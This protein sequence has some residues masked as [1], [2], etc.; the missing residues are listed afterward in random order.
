[1]H[2]NITPAHRY[3]RINQIMDQVIRMYACAVV[4][5][6]GN[7]KLKYRDMKMELR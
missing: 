3:V 2:H 6:L 4:H 7:F 5:F 1:M